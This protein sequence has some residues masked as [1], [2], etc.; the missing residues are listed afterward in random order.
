MA[1]PGTLQI[2]LTLLQDAFP[3]PDPDPVLV[4]LELDPSSHAF[5][6]H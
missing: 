4:S 1:L 3:P 5:N 6:V 2:F